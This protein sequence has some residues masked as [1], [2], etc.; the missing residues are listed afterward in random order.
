LQIAR[1][2]RFWETAGDTGRTVIHAG[3][4]RI[5]KQPSHVPMTPALGVSDRVRPL[6]WKMIQPQR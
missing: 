3:C 5:D 6:I 2:N 4:V 1:Y